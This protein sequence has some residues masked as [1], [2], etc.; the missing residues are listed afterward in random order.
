MV[1]IK[2]RENK[3]AGVNTENKKTEK[4]IAIF[5]NLVHFINL[6]NLNSLL[7]VRKQINSGSANV[8]SNIRRVE[9]KSYYSTVLV[10]AKSSLKS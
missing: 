7:S 6:L 4:C 3:E 2:K 1:L 10:G 9:L 5:C 8:N